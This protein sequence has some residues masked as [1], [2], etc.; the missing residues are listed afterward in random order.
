MLAKK[1]DLL[2]VPIGGLEQVGANSTMIGHNK[3]WIM[4]DL[5]ISFYNQYGI[6]ILIPDI[7]F[8][9]K[10]RE[11]IK[12][13]FVTHAHE[14]H[15]GAIPY[16]WQLLKCPIY[17]TEFPAA[18]LWQKFSEKGLTDKVPIKI[19][20]SQEPF[21][22]GSFE[23][24]YVPLAHSILGTCGIYIKTKAGS[25]FHTGDW[26]I[27]ETPLLGD[28]IDTRH[29]EQIGK[30]GVDILLC[31]STNILS[32]E[33]TGSESDVRNAL[34]EIFTKYKDKR[35][36][37]T[38]FASNLAR[39]ETILTIAREAGRKTAVI[40][41]SMHKMID[42]VAKTSYCSKAFKAGIS[43]IVSEEE[44][45]DMPAHKV[46]FVCTG[47][48]GE[49]RSALYRIARGENKN[50]KFSDK[51][52]VVFSSRII[53]GNE[54]GVR[55]L[56]N[57]IVQIGAGL[58]TTDTNHEIHVS[59]HPNQNALEKMYKWLKPKTFIPIHG[60]PYMLHAHERFVREKGIK[61]T[62]IAR[63]G[64]VIALRGNKLEKIDEIHVGM[65]CIDGND[66]IELTGPAVKERA[67]M[68]CNG[69]VSISFIINSNDN[70]SNTPDVSI[71]GIY[72][73]NDMQRRLQTL[74]YQTITNEI[75]M[76]FNDINS[77]KENLKKA[78]KN[79]IARHFSKK[80][81]VSVHIHRC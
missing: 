45:I 79:L 76:H 30:E 21:T 55:R 53:P 22:V 43:S 38:C 63:S 68:S 4:L 60:D 65:N 66:I 81:I 33:N 69:H 46:V 5:G 56:Q 28:K 59:G 52:I 27:D 7:T 36:T 80:P 40:G 51:D 61:E 17:A 3:E 37:V 6:E 12:G 31:D 25:L 50:I 57:L 2:I 54:L 74:I 8:P 26:K 72:I 20:K 42:A 23:I 15:I 64:D 41:R 47:S 24:E 78:V 18:V 77:L 14:D 16:L 58:I 62:I 29:M 13:L 35:L 49:S 1:D 67:A 73:H 32:D 9:M 10:V 75:A 34:K 11:N 70:L 19:V 44:A 39:I 71:T 48:Q